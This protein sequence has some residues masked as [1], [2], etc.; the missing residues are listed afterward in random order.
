MS[1][2]DISLLIV[3]GIFVLILAIS[4]IPAAKTG[5]AGSSA[6]KPPGMPF[7]V[8][9]FVYAILA[10]ALALTAA[11]IDGLVTPLGNTGWTVI[12]SVMTVVTFGFTE[13]VKTN[14]YLIRRQAGVG[15]EGEEE[16]L[17]GD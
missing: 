9:A 10:A 1:V 4:L 12:G 5:G 13:C 16:E 2:F 15:G 11:L 8:N 7:M 14:V 3:G 6:P 17:G